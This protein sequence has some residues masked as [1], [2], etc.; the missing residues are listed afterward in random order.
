M[1]KVLTN[2]KLS[3]IEDTLQEELLLIKQFNL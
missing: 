1:H 2:R 3:Y